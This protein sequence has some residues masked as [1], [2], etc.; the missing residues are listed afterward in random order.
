[1]QQPQLGTRPQ[2]TVSLAIDCQNGELVPAEALLAMPESDFSKLRREAM[3]ARV[4][5]RQGGHS[6]RYQCAICK[7][8]LYLSRRITGVQNRWFVH[9]GKS[10]DC[11]W[12]EG[13]RLAPDQ[14]K[15][16]VYR[17]QQEGR[18]HRELKEYIA[19]WLSRDPLVSNVNCEQTTF[20]EVVRGEWRR[21]DVKCLYGGIKLVFEIQL[22]YT[23]L[24]DVI[25]RDAF[26]RREKTFVIWVF[27]KFD[28][29]R[30]VVTDEAFFNKRNLFVI[31]AKARQHTSERSALTFCGYHQM[32]TLDDTLRWRDVWQAI[33]ISMADL[34]LPID[35]WRP[36][37]FDYDD[38]RKRIEHERIE[39]SRAEKARQWK[40]TIAAY[41][42]AALRYFDSGHGEEQQR[43]LLDV[44]DELKEQAEWHP[45]IEG[46]REFRFYGYH[47]VLSVLLSI[48][49][50]RPVSYSSQLSVFQVIEAGLRT[51]SRVGL[52]AY[53]ILYL[54]AYKTYRPAMSVKHQKWLSQYAHK[55]KDSF[56]NGESIYR[57]DTSFDKSIGLLF[58][59]LD[60]HLL[61]QFGTDLMDDEA[62]G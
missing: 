28:P 39:A 43:A 33:P 17:G 26:Y 2:Q 29:S 60:Q 10:L 18:C 36:Y 55:I 57:R 56:I 35:T 5:R 1:M 38:Q 59:E 12:Y 41:R 3:E 47:G 53:A 30:A 20:S 51:A 22:S 16:L 7:C 37:F 58:P 27:A 44:A 6:V 11:P 42:H 61:S 25:A 52:H 8:P 32:P 40:A 45:G 54:W 31:D 4:D 62:A 49:I 21:P 24:S 15:A 14:I 50:G 48:Q 13:N 9:D 19:Y 34:K 46:L 23:F